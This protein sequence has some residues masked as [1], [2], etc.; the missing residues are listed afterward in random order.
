MTHYITRRHACLLGAG[1]LA[2]AASLTLTCCAKTDQ[3][4]TATSSSN[5]QGSISLAGSTSM[6]KMCEALSE[7]FMEAYPNVRVSVEYTGS[8]AGI[9]SLTSGL[10]NIANSSRELSQA[11]K[12]SGIVGNV[13]AL[14]G[15]AVIVNKANTCTSITKS[16]LKEIFTRSIASWSDVGG[17][18]PPSLS[19]AAR[20]PRV[21]V[22]HSKSLLMLKIV[23]CM[24]KSSIQQG[25]YLQKWPQRQAQLDIFR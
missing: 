13:V 12:S 5:L 15:I 19:L 25:P 9:E 14:D 23:A 16:Q 4:T 11:E 3:N 2:S 7:G 6:E 1:L 17:S 20:M 24:L 22:A 21:H 8:S 18:D 10:C